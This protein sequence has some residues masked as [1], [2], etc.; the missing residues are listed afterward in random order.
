METREKLIRGQI[1]TRRQAI[2]DGVSAEIKDRM[3]QEMRVFE[4]ELELILAEKLEQEQQEQARLVR[5]QVQ[6]EKVQSIQLPHNFDEVFG[7][8]RANEIITEVI[9]EFQ[10][11]AY[12]EHNAEVEGI[13]NS[14]RAQLSEAGVREAELKL[15]ID[16]MKQE[17]DKG[18][19]EKVILIRDNANYL[20]FN[21]KLETVKDDAELKRDAAVRELETA[22][23]EINRLNSHI[24]DLRKEIAV[25][26]K[27][28]YK[29]TDIGSNNK[30]N[31]LVKQSL[32]EKVNK[33]LERW[34]KM[35]PDIVAPPEITVSPFRGDDKAND[36]VVPVDEP[37]DGNDTA[38]HT[39]VIF[40]DQVEGVQPGADSGDNGDQESAVG[41]LEE[42]FK[43]IDQLERAVYG[44]PAQEGQV[45]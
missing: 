39:E 20:K 26:A 32:E 30:L 18:I 36:T 16:V 22:Q 13:H 43:R 8:P 44:R 25:G 5:V 1:D 15:K 41:T 17:I 14:Y 29:V 27:E 37:A 28:A 38:S 12:E 33:G 23:Q 21:H 40:R 35:M 42:A 7:D 6:E 3:E 9:R 2:A 31:A 10:R 19:E 11:Q 45:A 4:Q 24:D 34:S